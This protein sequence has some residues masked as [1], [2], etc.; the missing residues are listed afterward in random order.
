MEKTSPI[1]GRNSRIVRF[2]G[3]RPAGTKA[4]RE[5]RDL[6][7]G[8]GHDLH[9]VRTVYRVQ[10]PALHLNPGKRCDPAEPGD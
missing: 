10:A 4:P 5:R 3:G 8:D 2:T 1:Q 6:M 9:P 7:A